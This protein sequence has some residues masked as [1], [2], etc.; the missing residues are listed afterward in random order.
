MLQTQQQQHSTSLIGLRT[1]SVLELVPA[2]VE[3]CTCHLRPCPLILRIAT[4]KMR[5]SLTSMEGKMSFRAEMRASLM[6]MGCHRQSQ[7]PRKSSPAAIDSMKCPTMERIQQAV[8]AILDG[9]PHPRRGGFS[10]SSP[11]SPWAKCSTVG[12]GASP[13]A[14]AAAVTSRPISPGVES[15][16]PL[17]MTS[18]T[19][20]GCH[21]RRQA[22][23][24]AG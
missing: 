24:Y 23:C 21:I 14:G 9:Q 17:A 6:D 16:N 12:A 18:R 3:R 10:W 13:P 20:T 7:I 19:G 5:S 11:S 1:P 4:E 8:M 2:N 22:R 15:V